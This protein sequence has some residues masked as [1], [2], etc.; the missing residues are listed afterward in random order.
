MIDAYDNITARLRASGDYL[1]P[2]VFRLIMFGEFWD[3]GTSKLCGKNWFSDLAW[4]DRQRGFPWPFSAVS[5][6]PH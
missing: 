1:W 5:T 4:E 3:S 2:L 6:E